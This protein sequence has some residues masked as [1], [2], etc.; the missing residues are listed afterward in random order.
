MGGQSTEFLLSRD[1]WLRPL[2]SLDE[3]T[4][5]LA[6]KAVELLIGGIL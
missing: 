4:V 3:K 2:E 1:S 5:K 6:E